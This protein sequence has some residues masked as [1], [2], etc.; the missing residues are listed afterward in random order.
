MSDLL[1]DADSIRHA[2]LQNPSATEILLL[3]HGHECKDLDALHWMTLHDHSS[4]VYAQ[5]QN[6]QTL[7]QHRVEDIGWNPFAGWT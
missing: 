4:S 2:M 5:L 6:L 7:T 1:I 3:A